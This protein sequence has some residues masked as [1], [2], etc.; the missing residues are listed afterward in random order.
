[1]D[2]V[3]DFTTG[4]NTTESFDL[5]PGTDPGGL[6]GIVR[7]FPPNGSRTFNQLKINRHQKPLIFSCG[8]M[9]T[10]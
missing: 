10:T 7:T 8:K 6:D 9:A 5:W 4:Q 2:Y 3:L 1:M